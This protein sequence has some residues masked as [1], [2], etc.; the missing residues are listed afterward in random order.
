MRTVLIAY[1]PSLGNAASGRLAETIMR[2]G[3]RWA[4]P[5]PGL[6]YVETEETVDQLSARLAPVVSDLDSVVVQELVGGPAVANTMLRWTQR[7]PDQQ[8]TQ[9]A[10]RAGASAAVLQLHPPRWRTAA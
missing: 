6:W 4:H 1:D 5:L 9:S 2:V 10:P 7:Y 3:P 8:P